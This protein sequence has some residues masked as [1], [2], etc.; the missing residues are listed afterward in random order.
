MRSYKILLSNLGYARGISGRLSHH[1]L[2]AHRHLFCNPAVQK[3]SLQQ[4]SALI[5]AEN[6]DI[7]CFVEIDRGSVS[8]A[9]F[10]QLQEL[11]NDKYAY[12]DI[13]NKYAP[14][15][16]LRSFF[17]TRGNCNAF[18]AKHPFPHEK[19]YFAS[20]IKRL[21]YRV[22]IEK[23][24]T[25][26]FAHFSLNRL[27]RARQIL[28]VEELMKAAAGEAIFL[29]DFNIL[30]GLEEIAP[31][32]GGGQF[33]LLN[34]ADA[35]TFTFHKR[36]LVLDL[37]LCSKGIARRA[38]LKV[39]PQPFSD[40]AALVLEIGPGSVSAHGRGHGGDVMADQGDIAAGRHRG[41]R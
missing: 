8:S 20:G 38:R 12:F 27:V 16:R 28:Q 32:L 4:L 41:R 37:C 11:V 33:V 35:P 19:I 5:A 23:D 22:H 17:V 2:Y 34:R 7:C 31:L 26:F 9:G 40:H 25:L 39:I 24:L 21:V 18:I 30:T 6:P 15:S 3:R 10:N 1:L 29:G 14:T 36:K 13:E